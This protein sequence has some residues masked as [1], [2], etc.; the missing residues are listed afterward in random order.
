MLLFFLSKFWLRLIL[1][2]ILILPNAGVHRLNLI[3]SHTVS[4]FR[5]DLLLEN[6]KN[7][8]IPTLYT[9]EKKHIISLF[10]IDLCVF[11]HTD[12]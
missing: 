4:G 1:K 9:Y 6:D 3:T 2:K 5:K 10:L 7:T 11:I 12:M 8:F